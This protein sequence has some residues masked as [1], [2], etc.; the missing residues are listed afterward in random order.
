MIDSEEDGEHMDGRV[1]KQIDDYLV[2]KA[3]A[4]IM[5]LVPDG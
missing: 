1:K 2:L 4:S 3:L 5:N